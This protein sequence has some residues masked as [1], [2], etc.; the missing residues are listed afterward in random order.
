VARHAVKEITENFWVA[1]LQ[2]NL[3][4][5]IMPAHAMSVLFLRLTFSRKYDSLV[6]CYLYVACSL[7]VL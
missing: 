2:L 4:Q 3:F 7:S 5:F 6:N 1:I